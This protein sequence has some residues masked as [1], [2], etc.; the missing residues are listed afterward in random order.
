MSRAPAGQREKYFVYPFLADSLLFA[1]KLVDCNLCP[2][3]SLKIPDTFFIPCSPVT[4]GGDGGRK[5]GAEKRG[6]KKR[7]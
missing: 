2:F 1:T 5:R 3:E 6:A 4:T 7:G